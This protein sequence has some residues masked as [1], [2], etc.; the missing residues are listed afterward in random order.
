MRHLLPQQ[1]A[2]FKIIDVFEINRMHN[3]NRLATVGIRYILSDND[4]ETLWITPHERLEYAENRLYLTGL[5]NYN[6]IEE[7]L[8]KD[9][10]K[11]MTLR[12]FVDL[13]GKEFADFEIHA[14]IPLDD[15]LEV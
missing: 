1:F 12:K 10:D 13:I 11:S 4:V 8:S 6:K 5:N 9:L 14:A 2:N 7:L 3:S 15:K